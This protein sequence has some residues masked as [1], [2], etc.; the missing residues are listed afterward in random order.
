MSLLLPRGLSSR[1]GAIASVGASGSGGTSMVNSAANTKGAWQQLIAASARDACGIVVMIQGKIGFASAAHL[2]DI[3]VGAASS[4][5]VIAGNLAANT[6]N[7]ANSTSYYF[8]PIA[9]PAGSRVAARSQNSYS[10]GYEVNVSVLLLSGDMSASLGRI[11]TCGAT[12]ASTAGTNIDPGASANTKGAWTQIIAATAFD[13]R[14][15]VVGFLAQGGNKAADLQW[16]FDVGIGSAAS[17]QI[18]VPDVIAACDT[19]QRIPG[20]CCTPFL[21]IRIPAGSR[22]A[23]RAACNSAAAGTRTLDLIVYGVG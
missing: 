4:E 23:A 20:T 9:I 8:F 6:N 3:G 19:D 2:V 11:E 1:A 17:E 7:W 13:Y 18:V 21:P 15:L 10:S 12:P 14:G 22:I 5:Q 16:S